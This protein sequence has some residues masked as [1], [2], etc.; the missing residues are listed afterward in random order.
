MDNFNLLFGL[1]TTGCGIY[2]LYLWIRI[3][4]LG[5]LPEGCFLIPKGCKSDE[6]VDE[7]EY[8]QLL[9]PRLL[10]FSLFISVVG[11]FTLADAAFGLLETWTAAMSVG[12]RLLIMELATCI[13]PLVVVIW[14]GLDLRRIQ[15]KLWLV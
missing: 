8:R 11:F 2:C 6:C 7:E 9:Q 3:R 1:I 12:M 13:I 15:K 4:R 10:I 5:K 14:F